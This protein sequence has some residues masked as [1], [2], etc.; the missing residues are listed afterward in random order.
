[1][2]EAKK[3]KTTV[4]EKSKWLKNV[5]KKFKSNRRGKNFKVFKLV[6]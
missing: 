1:M 3:S 2:A 5:A 4:A 6:H